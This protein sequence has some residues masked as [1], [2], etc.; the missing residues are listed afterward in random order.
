MAFELEGV[1]IDRCI[2][3]GGTWLDAGELEWIAEQA[4]VDPGPITEA[5][6][7][8][9]QRGEQT[10]LKCP[11]CRRRMQ[12][13]HVGKE[14]AVELDRCRYEHGLW[15]D[16]GEMEKVIASFAEGEGGAVARFFGGLYRH[17]VSS[18][19]KGD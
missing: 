15:F 17:D 2:S 1:E 13:I 14:P 9:H 4:G 8:K 10:D 7:T 16:E 11:R 3:C 12:V 5:L 18:R 6:H 19:S